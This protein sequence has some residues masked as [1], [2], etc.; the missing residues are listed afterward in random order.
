M[1]SKPELKMKEIE[2]AFG[3]SLCRCTGYR[4]IL[5]S[6]KSFAKDAPPS[7]VNQFTDIEVRNKTITLLLPTF[8]FL[9]SQIAL[10]TFRLTPSIRK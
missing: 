9:S 3:G 4:P 5:D 6:F 1:K 10:V 8:S 7:L 2:N